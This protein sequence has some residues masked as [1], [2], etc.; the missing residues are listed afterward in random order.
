MQAGILFIGFLVHPPDV[1][2]LDGEK[3]KAV[4][5]FL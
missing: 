4:W 5:I 1:S 2:M 3:H